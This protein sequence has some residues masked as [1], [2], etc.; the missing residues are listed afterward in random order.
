MGGSAVS[1]PCKLAA[2]LLMI[3]VLR[4]RDKLPS[5]GSSC[6]SV[7]GSDSEASLEDS[8][9]GLSAESDEAS[10]SEAWGNREGTGGEEAIERECSCLRQPAPRTVPVRLPTI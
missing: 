9:D 1:A 8:E 3:L 10:A 4:C 7:K 2:A 6:Q 5:M